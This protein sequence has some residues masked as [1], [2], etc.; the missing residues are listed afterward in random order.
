MRQGNILIIEHA[1]SYKVI[2]VNV[3]GRVLGLMAPIVL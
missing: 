2:D 3:I 1:I